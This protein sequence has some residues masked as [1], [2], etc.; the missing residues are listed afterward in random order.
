LGRD[1]GPSR[2]IPF[3]MKLNK[4]ELGDLRGFTL[5]PINIWKTQ[6]FADKFPSEKMRSIQY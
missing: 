6:P 5:Q 4:Q 3:K 1:L 2:L